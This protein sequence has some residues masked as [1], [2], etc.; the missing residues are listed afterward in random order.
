MSNKQEGVDT[1]KA[2]GSSDIGEAN[3]ASSVAMRALESPSYSKVSVQNTLACLSRA[4]QN[5]ALSILFVEPRL[6]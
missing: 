5:C 3:G 4:P 1:G 2:D 6:L